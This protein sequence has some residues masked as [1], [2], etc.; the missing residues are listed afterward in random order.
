MILSGIRDEL[1]QVIL[2]AGIGKVYRFVPEKP[3]PPCAIIEPDSDFINVYGD[4]FKA[5]YSASWKVQVIVPFAS[6]QKETENLDTLLESLIP[7]LWENTD[8]TQLSVDKPFMLEVNGAVFLSTNINLKVDIQ[9][10]N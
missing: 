5:D 10:G 3:V 2:A 4:Q 1:E 6:N 9:G 8:A 7:A